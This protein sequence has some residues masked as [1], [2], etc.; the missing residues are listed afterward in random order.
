M[1]NVLPTTHVLVNKAILAQGVNCT[2]AAIF[3]LVTKVFAME[4]EY[5]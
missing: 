1:A 5:V 3:Y 2:T 4:K